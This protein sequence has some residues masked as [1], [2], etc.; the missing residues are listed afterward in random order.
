MNNYHIIKKYIVK[1]I[2]IRIVEKKD[3]IRNFSLKDRDSKGMDNSSSSSNSSKGDVR[4]V[5]L[6]CTMRKNG[7]QWLVTMH[8]ESGVF[9][10]SDHVHH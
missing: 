4:Y 8:D 10:R 5:R 2:S 3:F 1:K 6:L 9:V 7:G